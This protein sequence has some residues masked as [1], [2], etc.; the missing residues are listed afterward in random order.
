MQVFFVNAFTQDRFGGNPAAVVPLDEEIPESV[1]QSMAAQHNLSETAFISRQGEGYDIRWFTPTIE[2]ALC[3]HATLAS[4]H[5]LFHHL[6]FEPATVIF[7]SRS[8]PLPVSRRED[9][10][11]S[12]DFPVNRPAGVGHLES[13]EKGLGARPVSLYQSTY[14]FMAV[15]EKQA[16]LEHLSPD[17]HVLSQIRSRGVIATA[18]GKEVD[19]V[20]RC[21]YPQS[22]INEDPV[23]GSAHTVMAPYWAERLGRKRLRA[24]QISKRGGELECELKGERVLISGYA[25]TY[26][27]G[28]ICP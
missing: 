18:P 6:G 8:G 10:R 12:M 4:A 15:F 9:E 26:L 24:K 14:D 19:F 13:I 27:T 5:V 7:H 20:S 16:D 3:G 1:M 28:E 11:L 23:T 2:V 22:G 21:F 25:R 17:F